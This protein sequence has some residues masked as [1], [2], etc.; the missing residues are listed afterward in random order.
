MKIELYING[1]P[2]LNIW[3]KYAESYGDEKTNKI[4][5]SYLNIILLLQAL[6]LKQ[7]KTLD[8]SGYSIREL[9]KIIDILKIEHMQIYDWSFSW[10]QRL[11]KLDWLFNIRNEIT[12]GTDPNWIIKNYPIL[13]TL[14]LFG[15][16]NIIYSE[17]K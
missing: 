17:P 4:L 13:S 16:L 8:E 9:G 10:L 11:I 3:L 14:E 2:E 5:Q 1:Q 7:S 15:I 6:G 12:M